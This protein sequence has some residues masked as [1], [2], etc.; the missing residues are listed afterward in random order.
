MKASLFFLNDLNPKC[1]IG[2]W[3]DKYL[4]ASKY[5]KIWVDGVLMDNP[6]YAMGYLPYFDISHRAESRKWGVSYY[7]D[8]AL[9]GKVLLT[10]NG[11]IYDCKGVKTTHRYFDID[12]GFYPSSEAT[13]Q[14]EFQVDV[15]GDGFSLDEI[16]ILRNA[17][18][19]GDVEIQINY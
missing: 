13:Y 1:E 3:G 6:L 15:F 11:G 2:I 14:N 4:K 10:R 17:L 16:N 19:L 9:N 5:P 8:V 7:W 12:D 18:G